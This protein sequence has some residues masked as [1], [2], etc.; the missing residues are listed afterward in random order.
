MSGQAQRR[1]RRQLAP[2]LVSALAATLVI[3]GVLALPALLR[4]DRVSRSKQDASLEAVRTYQVEAPKHVSGRVAYPQSPPVGGDHN[5]VWLACGHH[6]EPVRNEM[7][8]HDLEHGVVWITYRP[9]LD[10]G[11]VA[12]LARLLPGKGIMSP[13]ENLPAPVVV[14]VWGAQLLLDGADDPRMPLFLAEYGDGST[15]PE[16]DASCAGGVGEPVPPAIDA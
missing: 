16:R 12:E 9:D 13:Y 6:D 10:A 11:E 2:V 3:V 15:A 5:R 8:V 7:A 4:G 14:T 1:P